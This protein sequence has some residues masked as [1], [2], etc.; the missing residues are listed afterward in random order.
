M[1]EVIASIMARNSEQVLRRARQAAM[2]GADW[3]ELRLDVWPHEA[4]LR[5]LIEAIRLPVLIACRTPHDGG[6]FHPFINRPGSRLCQVWWVS[7]GTY[8]F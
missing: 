4:D 5:H 1:A 2:A 6:Q 8:A 3:L 7:M